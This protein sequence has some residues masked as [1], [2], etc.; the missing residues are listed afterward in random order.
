MG[1]KSY[2]SV[3]PEYRSIARA[4]V[5]AWILPGALMASPW[6]FHGQI[7]KVLVIFS[8]FFVAVFQE[9]NVDIR[10]VS[11][12]WLVFTAIAPSCAVWLSSRAYIRHSGRLPANASVHLIPIMGF[13]GASVLWHFVGFFSSGP[14]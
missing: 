1:I 12:W 7:K 2:F 9:L 10:D 14:V 3:V 5:G 6:L 11:A 4:L 13:F 8:G